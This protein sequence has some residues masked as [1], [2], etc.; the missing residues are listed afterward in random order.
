[1]DF[2]LKWF[3]GSGPIQAPSDFKSIK[4]K[5]D[6]YFT[7]NKTEY[8]FVSI[9][10]FQIEKNRLS[11]LKTLNQNMPLTYLLNVYKA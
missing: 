9:S 5:I 3:C 8:L 11:R 2:L 10:S 4:T 1:M 7:A 6:K